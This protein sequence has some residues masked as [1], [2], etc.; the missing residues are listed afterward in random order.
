MNLIVNFEFNYLPPSV[1]KLYC[2][3]RKGGLSV[4]PDVLAF[5]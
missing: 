4:Y 5:K 2:H 1:N 3:T